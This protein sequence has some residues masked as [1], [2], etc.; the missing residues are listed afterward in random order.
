MHTAHS[1]RRE[2]VQL[3]PL[4]ITVIRFFPDL[5]NQFFNLPQ[6]LKTVHFYNLSGFDDVTPRHIR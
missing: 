4:T 1:F 5:Q 3:P 2:K 6:L